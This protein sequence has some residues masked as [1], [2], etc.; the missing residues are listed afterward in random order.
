MRFIAE[1]PAAFCPPI[2]KTLSHGNIGVVEEA[3]GTRKAAFRGSKLNL[4]GEPLTTVRWLKT[5]P[6]TEALKGL[7]FFANQNSACKLRDAKTLSKCY[8]YFGIVE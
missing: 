3:N 4:L 8:E 7:G 1:F 2:G 6:T 5:V